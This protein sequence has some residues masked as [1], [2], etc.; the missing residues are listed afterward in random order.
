[1]AEGTPLTALK[2]NQTACRVVN[3]WLFALVLFVTDEITLKLTSRLQATSLKGV[4]SFGQPPHWT[5]RVNTEKVTSLADNESIRFWKS[6]Q[7]ISV[8]ENNSAGSL[9]PFW[10]K[11][12]FPCRFK[13]LVV[14]WGSSSPSATTRAQYLQ[15]FVK[16]TFLKLSISLV[17]Q[18]E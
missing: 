1:M 3:A 6:S 18:C 11:F 17:I 2:V 5:A 12:N 10:I 7:L 8:M 15:L 9:R 13:H 14:A 16:V 4:E